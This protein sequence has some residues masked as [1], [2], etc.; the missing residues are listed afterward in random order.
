MVPRSC[1]A[2]GY[3]PSYPGFFHFFGIFLSSYNLPTFIEIE[4]SYFTWAHHTNILSRIWFF[5][6]QTESLSLDR[7]REWFTGEYSYSGRILIALAV[8]RTSPGLLS[9]FCICWPYETYLLKSSP[10]YNSPPIDRE[11]HISIDGGCLR[12]LADHR[13]SHVDGFCAPFLLVLW[14][15]SRMNVSPPPHPPPNKNNFH[16]GQA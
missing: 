1:N 7:E 14:L 15:A 16:Y 13:P 6:A 12:F 8:R 9:I 2:F 11:A 3:R 10:H 4:D 5:P